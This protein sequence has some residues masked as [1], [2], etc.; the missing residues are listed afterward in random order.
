[1]T[2]FAVAEGFAACAEYGWRPEER[3]LKLQLS[4]LSHGGAV[5]FPEGTGYIPGLRGR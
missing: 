5:I 2:V 1:M 3:K 4:P